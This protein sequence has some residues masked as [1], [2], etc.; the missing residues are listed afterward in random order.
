MQ[1]PLHWE[2]SKQL[3]WDVSMCAG[4]AHI[5][6]SPPHGGQ[7]EFTIYNWQTAYMFSQYVN[8]CLDL[9]CFS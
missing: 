7:L 2:E 6:L 4:I 1:T 8:R 3:V 5:P 9:Y